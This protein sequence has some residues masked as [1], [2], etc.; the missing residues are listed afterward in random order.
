MSNFSKIKLINLN[1]A[2]NDN[3][4]RDSGSQI[5]SLYKNKTVFFINK[6]NQT[7]F[8]FKEK[9]MKNKKLF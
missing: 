5:G 1:Y 7:L 3:Y 9:Y 4:N 8:D 6:K 2:F